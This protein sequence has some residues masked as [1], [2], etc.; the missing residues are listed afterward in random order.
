MHKVLLKYF[1]LLTDE[2]QRRFEAM[3]TLYAEWN[4]RINVISRRDFENFYINHVLHSLSIAKV[5]QFNSNESV[6]DLGTGGGFPGIPLAVLFPETRFV[7]LD[8]ISKKIRVVNEVAASLS[9]TNVV[10]V[11]TRS[12]EHRGQ[13][14]FVVT[15][16][17]AGFPDIIRWTTKNINKKNPRNGIFALKG[18]DLTG[19]MAGLRGTITTW[20]LSE[21]F[22][23]P[24]FETKKIIWLK[25]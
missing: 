20:R 12:E 9:L 10:A 25:F 15:R 8:S 1:P 17:V 16:A 7:L 13:Y 4:S 23:E 21:M 5:F 18:G 14:N 19:E 6:L 24:F 3:E 22:D 2:Q 11:N